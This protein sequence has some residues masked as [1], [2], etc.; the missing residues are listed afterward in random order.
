MEIGS[1]IKSLRLLKKMTQADLCGD[2]FTRNML[3][4]IEN[5]R[6]LPSLPALEYLCDKL[7]ISADYFFSSSNDPLPYILDRKLPYFRKLYHDGK[8]EKL[9]NESQTFQNCNSVELNLMLAYSNLYLGISSFDMGDL[10]ASVEYYKAA[11]CLYSE[12]GVPE[13]TDSIK[14]TLQVITSFECDKY[15]S[16]FDCFKHNKAIP[17]FIF[18]LYI[19]YMVDHGMS[20]KAASLYDTIKFE[21]QPFKFHINSRLAAAKFNYERAKELLYQLIFVEDYHIPAPFLKKML[22]E[23]EDYC[24]KTSDYKTA[25]DCTVKKNSLSREY[26]K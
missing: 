10:K 17:D 11:E 8:H 20:E 24:I 26:K 12:L 6:A 3:S 9:I 5:S 21:Y 16:P 7:E 15:P 13:V 4:A 14:V 19:V 22:S 23:L 2:F 1:K 18:Y 25:Y